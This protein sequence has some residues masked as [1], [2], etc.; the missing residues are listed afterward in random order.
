[1]S[2]RKCKNI[3]PGFDYVKKPLYCGLFRSLQNLSRFTSYAFKSRYQVLREP[4]FSFGKLPVNRSKITFS[5]YP[6]GYILNQTG[7]T[8][9]QGQ[10][11]SLNEGVQKLYCTIIFLLSTIFPFIINVYWYVPADSSFPFITSCPLPFAL[12]EK[13]LIILPLMSFILITAVFVLAGT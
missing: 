9:K 12:I 13:D 4:K 7:L 3:Y 11:I 8:F 10:C 1:M 6:I 5:F 2:V